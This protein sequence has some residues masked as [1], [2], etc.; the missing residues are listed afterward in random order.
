MARTQTVRALAAAG[1]GAALAAGGLAATPA[2]A[3]GVYYIPV[4]DRVTLHGHGYGHGHGLSQYG[5]EGAARAGH[6]YREILARYYPGTRLGRARGGIRVLVTADTTADVTVSRATGLRLRDLTRGRSWV[7]PARRRIDRWR[8]LPD[9]RVQAH[10]PR[11]WRR[12][13]VPGPR[14]RL[15]GDGE[16]SAPGP[17]TLWVPG[18]GGD[19]RR[20]Y[21]GRLRATHG[22]TVNVVS[23]DGYLRGV[24]PAEMPA[25]WSLEALKAQAVA[26][27]TYA[28][29]DR[30]ANRTRHYQTCDTTSCQ[31]YGGVG[32]EEPR[33]NRAVRR[34]ARRILR[35]R[36]RPAFTQFS[37]SSGG[38]TS[39]GGYPYLPARRDPW[40]DWSGNGVHTWRT[41]VD[42]SRLERRYRS[43]G[44]L[45]AIKVT[46]R[47]GNGDW[48]GRVLGLLLDG[49]RDDVRISGD[50]FRWA[51]GLRSTWFRIERTPIMTR[52]KRIG[53][54]ASRVGRPA[55]AEHAAGRDGSV[56]RFR[57]GRI[58]WHRRTGARETYGRILREYLRVGGPRS[59]LGYPR[60]G[61]RR[62]G[63]KDSVVV[64]QR[65][66]IYRNAP[67][68]VH[69]LHHGWL[70]T[71]RRVG[72]H[73]GR[74]GLPTTDVHRVRRGKRM[75]FRG[76]VITRR[77]AGVFR[78]RFR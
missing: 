35:H 56:Q 64:Y 74:L 53:G 28:A 59:L 13:D 73:R 23:L 47:D 41:S 52:W 54:A 76:G 31:V 26:A 34:T 71:Y 65:G 29:R 19:A 17:L 45:L 20:Q 3:A 55:G 2:A 1:L 49:S 61:V 57:E 30:A 40:D 75:E 70:R 15:P 9:G 42:V 14:T 6:D 44:R 10:R 58:Y 50:D 63:R 32:A 46:R 68:G 38:W 21:R 66:R 37:A 33:T 39:A 43:L 22:D 7:L 16:F 36:G 67:T 5:A 72:L 27:R 62:I 18:G 25:S 69:L 48:N 4:T 12:W 51:F 11:G 8:I 24:V 60:T 78:V 77:R